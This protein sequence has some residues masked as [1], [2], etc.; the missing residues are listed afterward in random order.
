MCDAMACSCQ[1]PPLTDVVAD[2][3]RHDGQRMLDETYALFLRACGRNEKDEFDFM[4]RKQVCQPSALLMVM[5]IFD[6]CDGH[7]RSNTQDLLTPV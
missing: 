7:R 5:R 1:D 6:K 3:R 4:T 2:P